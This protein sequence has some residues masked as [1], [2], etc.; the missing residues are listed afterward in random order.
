M[1]QYV[2]LHV[3]SAMVSKFA[4]EIEGNANKIMNE[5]IGKYCAEVEAQGVVRSG[6]PGSEILKL[7]RKKEVGMIVMGSHGRKGIDKIVFGS[8][9]EKVIKMSKVAVFT[10]TP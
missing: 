5:F 1:T 10:V 6:Y 7:A 9:A 8:Q 4:Q 2:G 3:P